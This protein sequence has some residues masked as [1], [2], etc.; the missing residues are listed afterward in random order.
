MVTMVLTNVSFLLTTC[1]GPPDDRRKEEFLQEM[2][3]IKPASQIPWLIMGDFNLIYKA[4]DKNNLNLNRRLMGKFRAALDDCELMEI[5]LQNRK[6]TW[7]NERS[8]PTM[9]RLD[10]AFCNGEWELLFPNFAL[11]VLSTGASDHCPILLNRQ[12]VVP[13]KATFRFENHWLGV[14]GFSDVVQQAWNKVQVGKSARIGVVTGGNKGI[15]FKVCRQLA[16]NGVTV[17]LTARDETRGAEAVDKLTGLG[18]PD[19]IWMSLML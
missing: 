10:R 13:R 2:I 8:S 3:S 6:F 16:S 4:S 15:G 19:V 9:V 7:S 12:D 18:L 14:Q 17:V 11:H 5:C 1:N